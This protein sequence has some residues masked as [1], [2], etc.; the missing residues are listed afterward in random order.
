M[1]L[2]LQN[3]QMGTI[4]PLVDGNLSGQPFAGF[5]RQYGGIPGIPG[6]SGW[7]SAPAFSAFVDQVRAFSGGGFDFFQQLLSSLVGGRIGTVSLLAGK[8]R[9]SQLGGGLFLGF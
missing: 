3:L 7:R 5:L 2:V 8:G 6:A 9:F 4:F 1:V